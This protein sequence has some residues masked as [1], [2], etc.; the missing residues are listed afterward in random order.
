M[1]LRREKGLHMEIFGRRKFGRILLGSALAIL[2]AIVGAG[3][4]A[5][6]EV[7]EPAPGFTMPSTMGG[8]ISL[9]DFRGKKW[10]L[11]EFYGADFAPT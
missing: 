1:T 9:S 3:P 10:V 7:G 11:L 5:A 6:V 2:S 4:A 8:D